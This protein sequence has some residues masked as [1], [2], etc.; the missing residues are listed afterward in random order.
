VGKHEGRRSLG[1]PRCRCEDNTKMDL[2]DVGQMRD[3][4]KCGNERL[5]SIMYREFLD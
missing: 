3:S 4:C 1:K 5:G 2:Q